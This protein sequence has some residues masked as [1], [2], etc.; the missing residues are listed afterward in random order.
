MFG[1]VSNL[2]GMRRGP[3]CR[4][5]RVGGFDGCVQ[6]QNGSLKLDPIENPLDALAG[7]FG[8]FQL[9]PQSVH[10]ASL[11]HPS[12]EPASPKPASHGP[13]RTAHRPCPHRPAQQPFSRDWRR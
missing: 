8:P 1:R 12:P 4:F 9:S 11:R 6:R 5:C 3:G 7:A 2:A 13:H 10:N